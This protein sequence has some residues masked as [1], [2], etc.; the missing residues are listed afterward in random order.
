MFFVLHLDLEGITE[1][2]TDPEGKFVSFKV[3]TS[4]KSFLF[5]PLQGISGLK[6]FG[7]CTKRA[8]NIDWRDTKYCAPTLFFMAIN[9]FYS[10]ITSLWR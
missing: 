3:T 7:A 4:N 6:K 10:F 9:I 1:I 5:V 2:D 8:P